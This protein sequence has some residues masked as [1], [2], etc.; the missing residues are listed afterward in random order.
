M[1]EHDEEP[2]P[3]FRPPRVYPRPGRASHAETHE[4]RIAGHV[5]RHRERGSRPPRRD[6]GLSRAEIVGAAIAVADAEGPD[7]ISMRRIARELGA[8]VMSLY[9]YVESK[10]ELLDLMLD[11]VEGEIEVPEPSGDWRADLRTF[12]YRIRAGMSRH[13]WALEFIGSRPPSGPNDVRNLERMLGLLEGLDLQA[14]VTMDVMATV[15]TYVMGAVIREAQEVR[16]E[17]DRE[18]AEVN[19]TA[20]EKHAQHERFHQ[21]FEASG[22]YPRITRLM[23]SGVDPDDPQTRDERFEFGLSCVLDGI[24]AQR[25]ARR[26]P[27]AG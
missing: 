14:R 21:W 8:G 24:A 7:A 2:W 18:L 12:A 13:R 5:Q 19:L 27:T 3:F 6:R 25:S 15:A 9:W 23:E 1:G 16:G 26:G 22:R 20:E 4:Q 11:S 10:E 17:R